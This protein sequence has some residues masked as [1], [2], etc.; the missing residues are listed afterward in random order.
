MQRS[1]KSETHLQ[2][3]TERE[4][5]AEDEVAPQE[6]RSRSHSLTNN[7]LK[8]KVNE[9]ES[10]PASDKHHGL[11]DRLSDN[12]LKDS[13]Q[14]TSPSDAV[15]QE[16][17]SKETSRTSANQKSSSAR[18]SSIAHKQKRKHVKPLPTPRP[19][20]AK[21]SNALKHLVE[22]KKEEEELKSTSAPQSQTDGAQVNDNE[23]TE[24]N[25]VQNGSIE[26]G[27]TGSDATGTAKEQNPAIVEGSPS[28]KKTL[29]VSYRPLT[30]TL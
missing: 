16:S 30:N 29:P 9:S 5:G 20:Q 17:A 22:Q 12:Q 28:K 14:E 21:P 19:V 3:R 8:Q 23:N 27:P 2:P 26:N 6:K 18:P 25:H 13:G 11:E 7:T 15:V 24:T 10:R 4:K 1:S